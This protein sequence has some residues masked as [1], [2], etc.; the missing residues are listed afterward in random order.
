MLSSYFLVSFAVTEER[1]GSLIMFKR[2]ILVAVLALYLMFL[3]TEII[4][5]SEAKGL[6]DSAVAAWS[7]D[8]N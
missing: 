4:D 1:K 7:F 6:K 8:G 5:F 2:L 3:S